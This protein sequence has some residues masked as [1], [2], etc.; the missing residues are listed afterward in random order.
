MVGGIEV[1]EWGWLGMEVEESAPG[2]TFRTLVE[3]G[4]LRRE[5]VGVKTMS[6]SWKEG[7]ISLRWFW[8]DIMLAQ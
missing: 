4:E 1:A 3:G 5:R 8:Y 7:Y 6:Q 2:V